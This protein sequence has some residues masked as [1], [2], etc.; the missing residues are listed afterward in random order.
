MQKRIVC[1]S[2]CT[3]SETS[4]EKDIYFTYNFSISHTLYYFVS[5]S[6]FKVGWILAENE[7]TKFFLKSLL[8]SE[9]NNYMCFNIILKNPL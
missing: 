4:Q 8:L 9:H 1:N 2:R 7:I 3:L 5:Q 6:P